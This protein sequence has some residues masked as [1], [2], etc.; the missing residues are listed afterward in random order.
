MVEENSIMRLS[1]ILAVPALAFAMMTGGPIITH[2]HP[3]ICVC[4]ILKAGRECPP[5]PPPVICNGTCKPV[6]VN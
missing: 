1:A 5:C 4:P 2:P 6:I 3:V